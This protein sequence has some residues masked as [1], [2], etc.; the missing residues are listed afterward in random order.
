MSKL[1]FLPIPILVVAFLNGCSE[2]KEDAVIR[3]AKNRP[4]S[5]FTRVFNAT[6]APVSISYRG[7]QMGTAD[8]GLATPFKPVSAKS[9]KV[10][11][12]ING[13]P[14]ELEV[15]TQTNIGTTICVFGN[16]QFAFIN[17]EPRYPQAAINA[18]VLFLDEKM[19]P[20]PS[21][22][23]ASV[24]G[25]AGSMAFKA[26]ESSTSIPAGAWEGVVGQKTVD[27]AYFYTILFTKSGTSWV[28]HFL[29]NSPTDKPVAGGVSQ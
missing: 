19:Q 6:S 18:R 14:Q 16:N 5:A 1:N 21:G 23:T 27:P 17:D 13:K 29:V 26:E 11:L 12:T 8:P 9:A 10:A 3:A 25:P 2:S 24:K 4:K 22:A 15:T 20:V 7:I 28:P